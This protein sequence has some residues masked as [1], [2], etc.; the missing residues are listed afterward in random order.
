[1]H[2]APL[3]MLTGVLAS[4]GYSTGTNCVTYKRNELLFDPVVRFYGI[5]LNLPYLL[6]RV[7]HFRPA[8]KF[9]ISVLACC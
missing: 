3:K 2:L 8:L 6:V 7:D 4:Y 9:K 5:Q 1:M